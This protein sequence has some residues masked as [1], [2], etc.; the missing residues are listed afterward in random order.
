MH[1]QP[2]RIFITPDLPNS[3]DEPTQQ[4]HTFCRTILQSMATHPNLN[5]IILRYP[6]RSEPAYAHLFN[7]LK[8]T[9]PTQCRLASHGPLTH[10]QAS[11]AAH[12]LPSRILMQLTPEIVC[13]LRE[14]HTQPL[15]LS[16]A[17]HSLRQLQQAEHLALD[18]AILSPI[19]PTPSHPGAP[20]LGWEKFAKLAQQ[21][22]LP[23]Y[24]L[25]GLTPED[26]PIAQ[27]QGA[28]GIAGIRT[29]LADD[30]SS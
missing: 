25:G 30:Y 2:D 13:T 7:A 27:Q 1:S 14:S 19:L 24:A 22:T 9:L 12:H 21:V 3:A 4:I 6:S 26:L 15:W 16:A 11:S 28:K 5:H 10:C 20:T 23:I 8:A 17:C 18:A 29:F